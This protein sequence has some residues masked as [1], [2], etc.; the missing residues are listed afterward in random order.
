MKFQ[1][2]FLVF[3]FSFLVKEGHILDPRLLCLQDA[4]TVDWL[5]VAVLI[6]PRSAFEKQLVYTLFIGKISNPAN[7]PSS[8]GQT[9]LHKPIKFLECIVPDITREPRMFIPIL[10][11]S[12]A[13]KS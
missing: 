10:K 9:D 12:R 4:R 1:V 8:S 13:I 2:I 7:Y 5:L 6:Y 11:R 3:V